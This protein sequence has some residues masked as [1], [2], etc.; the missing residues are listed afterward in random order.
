ML[1]LFFGFTC[2]I[3]TLLA[4]VEVLTA[5]VQPTLTVRC[6]QGQVTLQGPRIK[7]QGE[8]EVDSS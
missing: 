2:I 8:E 6:H 5:D 1:P 4:G 7:K 3:E